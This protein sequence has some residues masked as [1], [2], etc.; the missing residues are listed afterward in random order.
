MKKKERLYLIC[1]RCGHRW[2]RR[3]LDKLPEVCPNRICK[4]PYW[5]V[6]RKEKKS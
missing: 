6:P 2:L 5:D 4:S 3:N 1:K